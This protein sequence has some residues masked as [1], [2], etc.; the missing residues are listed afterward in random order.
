MRLIDF[1]ARKI[2]PEHIKSAGY[3][4]VVAY[5]SESRP[6]ANFGAKPITREY[7]DALRAEGLHIVSN[8]QYGKPGGSA[9]SDFTRGFDGG[10]ADAR[11]AMRLHK[12]AGG[13][14]SAPII[15]SI[16]EDIDLDT[17]NSMGVEWF[18]GINSIL[19]VDRTGIYGHCRVCAWAIKDSV[20]GRSTTPGRRWVWQ[21]KA[22]SYGGREP[23]AVLFQAVIDTA[24]NPGPLVGGTRVDVN[25]VLAAD[26][27]QWDLDRSTPSTV[28]APDF[29][30]S[31]EIRSPYRG[32]RDGVKVL[33]FVLHTEDGNSGSARN[34]ARYL[35]N[36]PN[37]VSYHYTV[38]NDGHVYD[39]VD[40][41]YYA[42][43]VYQPGNS[44]SINLAFAGSFAGWSRQTWFDRMRHGIDV[45]A[46]IAVRDA[47]R[48]GL[49]TRVISPEEARRGATGIT[50]HNGVRIATGV[51]T[52]TDVG[53]GFDWDYFRHKVNEFAA[54]THAGPAI[55]YSGQTYPGS[56]IVQGATGRHVAMIQD[57]LN[58]VAD[59]GLLVDGE[60]APLTN[61]AIIAFQDSRGLVADGEVESTTWAELFSD[62][63]RIPRGGNGY[64]AARAAA[65][66]ARDVTG[67][68]I[69]TSVAMD[70]A[71]LGI[72]RWDPDRHAIAAMFGDNFDFVGLRGEWQSPSIVMYDRDY[73]VR[74]IPASNGTIRPNARRRQLW[75][76]EHDN[77]EY[78]TILPCDF[79]RIGDWWHVAVMVT[80]G[81]GDELR[82]EFHRSR[83]L[84]T[85]EVQPE[86]TLRHPSHP[87]NV[88]LTFDRIG[89]YVYIFGTGGL[90]RNRSIWMWRSPAREFPH[91]WEPW[92]WDGFRW[93]WGIANEATP[94][95]EGRFGEL[96]FRYLQGNCVLSYFDAGNYRQQ[97]RTVQA[98]EDNW[99]NGANV[100][101]YAFGWQIPQLYGGY[102][103]PLSRLN[104]GNG[105][106]F[107]VS[108]WNTLT[109]DPY[110]V[111]LVQDT[112]WARGPR[113]D[114]REP[115]AQLLVAAAPPHEAEPIAAQDRDRFPLPAGYYG[116]PLDG[117]EES[118]SN[119]AG[120][121]PQ[122][123]K[124]GL[125]RWQEA[126][127][128]PG[129][130]V[131]DATKQ[132][133]TVAEAAREVAERERGT[134]ASLRNQIDELRREVDAARVDA[135]AA[136]TA[137]AAAEAARDAAQEAAERERAAAQEAAERERAAA[138]EARQQL[139]QAHA[140]ARSDREALRTEH[141]EQLRQLRQEADDRAS[142]LSAALDVARAEADANRAQLDTATATAAPTKSPPP[143]S[144]SRRP[145]KA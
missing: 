94:I 100:V 26:F 41:E 30:E 98:P 131:Y 79:I 56:T 91:G 15:F 137:S 109:N 133:A 99:R 92:G 118:S 53:A 86:L 71:D 102:I 87:G 77:P 12:A 120:N 27:G 65:T 59:A 6:G 62:G 116:G 58:T 113:R 66:P 45:G 64:R 42:N 11:T 33:W 110:R 29:D 36:N 57:R 37:K 8:F 82:T 70:A 136:R 95:L 3:D 135:T 115:V 145:R 141:A 78:R 31:T 23:A 7:A 25:E 5:V 63:S 107:W 89:D 112:L 74:G 128:V 105:M 2:P 24:S 123:S 76:Y 132:A 49:Q 134:A 138:A 28:I 73:N 46:Y 14:D 125:T 121:E 83:D 50:D 106:H 104:E 143:A 139:D 144:K 96:S 111:M 88:M 101:D 90:A 80:K 103:S 67:P 44:R 22:W 117:P 142:A 39:V 52:H 9:P 40:T 68:G 122:H 127:G 114:Q 84:V 61:R 21:T 93:D 124:D 17:W 16:D 13:P 75:H 126:I 4:G 35:S 43:S 55:R 119:L 85:W 10:T 81:L 19:G 97:A 129:S 48:Y 108:Q 130:C 38:D 47:R 1:A 60:F 51:G 20:V 54:I 18:R 140:E 32:S 72:L 69:T 34:L